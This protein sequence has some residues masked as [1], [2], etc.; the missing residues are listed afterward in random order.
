MLVSGGVLVITGLVIG[1]G[2]AFKKIND[3]QNREEELEKKLKQEEEKFIKKIEYDIENDT[4]ELKKKALNS[5]ILKLVPDYD[6]S[7]E[8]EE[9]IFAKYPKEFTTPSLPRYN[10]FGKE[11]KI[12]EDILR[13][14]VKDYEKSDSYT[15]KDAY[16]YMIFEEVEREAKEIL[17]SYK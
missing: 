7:Y 8:T 6:F 13:E 2:V 1:V 3:K 12:F 10:L 16:Q 9:E 4:N 11:I 17:D 15:L 5:Y 14:K